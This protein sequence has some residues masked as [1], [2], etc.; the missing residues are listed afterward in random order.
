[1]SAATAS[2]TLL[3]IALFCA[4]LS[5]PA[6]AIV[7]LPPGANL[8]LAPNADG[9]VQFNGPLGYEL[10]TTSSVLGTVR[11]GAN[12]VRNSVYEFDLGAIPNTATID[13]VSLFITTSQTISNTSGSEASVS[14]V[15]FAGDGVVSSTDHQNETA[16]SALTTEAYAVGTASGTLLQI[17]L[18]SAGVDLVQSLLGSDLLTLRTQTVDFVTFNIASLEHPSLAAAA[19]SIDY[20]PIPLPGALGLFAPAAFGL[21]MRRRRASI[22]GPVRE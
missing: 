7:A 4:A 1:M 9:Y 17:D 18:G 16:G 12:N 8:S 3:P 19:L 14:F 6:S 2:R 5:D 10:N 13:A 21:W 20:T 22:Q 11:S 15:G